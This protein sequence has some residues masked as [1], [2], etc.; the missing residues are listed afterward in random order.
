MLIFCSF[1]SPLLNLSSYFTYKL[2]YNVKYFRG[3][4][5]SVFWSYHQ[6]ALSDEHHR[7]HTIYTKTEIQPA[8]ET[9]HLF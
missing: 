1:L 7:L 8:S 3:W 9:L 4:F 2:Q 6:V 5:C